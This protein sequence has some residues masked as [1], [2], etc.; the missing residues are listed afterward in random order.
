MAADELSHLDEQGHPRMVEVSSKPETLRRAVACGTL[1]FGAGILDRVLEGALPKGPVLEV[2]RIAGIMG[3]KRTAELI[4]LCHPLRLTRVTVDFQ[5]QGEARLEIR[6]EVTAFD[7]TGVEM[8]ALTAVS[9]AALT[10]YDMVKAI[11]RAMVIERVFLLEKEGGRSG[12][13]RMDTP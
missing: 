7:R 3:A 10:V 11:D 2:A 8:E 12:H 9:I 4:P 5:P 6:S 13:F 1:Q